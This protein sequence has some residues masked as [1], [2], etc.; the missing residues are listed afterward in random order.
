MGGCPACVV[1]SSRCHS[2][3]DSDVLTV[4]HFNNG[5]GERWCFEDGYVVAGRRVIHVLV[6]AF[7]R[8]LYV[9]YVYYVYYVE[10]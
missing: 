6:G 10:T 4:V 5:G 9:Y 1:S 3:E 2:D 7:C 8:A